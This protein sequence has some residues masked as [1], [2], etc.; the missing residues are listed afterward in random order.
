MIAVRIIGFLVSIRTIIQ[1]AHDVHAIDVAS[2][3]WA[4]WEKIRILSSDYDN[5]EDRLKNKRKEV[6]IPGESTPLAVLFYSFVY[7]SSFFSL[8]L[9][10]LRTSQAQSRISDEA[11][12]W[13][14]IANDRVFLAVLFIGKSPELFRRLT[15]I[16]E[17]PMFSLGGQWNLLDGFCR[18]IPARK[19]PL[20]HVVWRSIDIDA[21]LSNCHILAGK[22]L[23]WVSDS[24][25]GL[26]PV[27]TWR[28]S[29]F[30]ST[31]I[32]R[33]VVIRP[34]PRDTFSHFVYT[35]YTVAYFLMTIILYLVAFVS[36]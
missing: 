7:L 16:V 30:V 13:R 10:F 26:H 9:Y 6:L 5:N 14:Y 12:S 36:K 29:K 34:L 8:S 4:S 15:V 21:T 18:I 32:R 28:F 2:A 27:G 23:I 35:L 19:Q 17:D 33:C 11:P 25:I 3:P 31:L 1:R 22:T 24:L 20:S